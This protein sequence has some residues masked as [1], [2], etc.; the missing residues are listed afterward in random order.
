MNFFTVPVTG[1]TNI[2]LEKNRMK[3]LSISVV[4]RLKIPLQKFYL[5]FIS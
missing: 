4:S 2:Y 1:N 3:N 5:H